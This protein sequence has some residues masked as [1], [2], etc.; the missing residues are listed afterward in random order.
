MFVLLPRYRRPNASPVQV[1]AIFPESIAFITRDP[2]G[3]DAQVTIATP[4]RPLFQKPLGHG[5]F[6]LLAG[7]Q[8]KRDRFA[9]PIATDVDLG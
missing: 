1:L 3:T 8:E 6:V 5:D 2:L 4:D 9:L 7:S